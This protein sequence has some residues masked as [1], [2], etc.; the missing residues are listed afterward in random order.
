MR[1]HPTLSRPIVSPVLDLVVRLAVLGGLIAVAFAFSPRA[2]GQLPVQ[3]F[4]DGYARGCYEAVKGRVVTPQKA[5]EICDVALDQERLTNKNRAATLINRGILHM[6]SAHH[7]RAMQ[8]YQAALALTPNM[9]EAKINLGAMYYYLGRYSDAV[10][11]LDEGVRVEDKTAR[12]AAHF[13]RGLAYERLGDV[14][15]AYADYRAAVAIQPGFA[16]AEKQLQR[17]TVIPGNG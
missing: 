14:D 12:A 4:G 16:E 6:R 1:R 10:A 3:V 11:A 15:R 8:D 17:F 5:L 13:N 2:F 9:A 7:D